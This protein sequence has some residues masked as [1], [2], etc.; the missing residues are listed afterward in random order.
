MQ[1]GMRIKD[2]DKLE[3]FLADTS[4]SAEKA[5]EK[6][7]KKAGR[8]TAKTVRNHIPRDNSSPRRHAGRVRLADD[9]R[10]RLVT[11]KQFGGKQ[12]RV[13][14]GKP[15]GTLWH[16]L[17]KGGYKNRRPTNF[18]AAAMADVDSKID[19]LLDIALGEEF[20]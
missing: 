1:I 17:D 4:H 20:R 8:E 6:F 10:D 2:S 14:G 9:V 13:S 15:T 18:M 19:P 12:I 5:K 3:T 11:D 16:I 7:L